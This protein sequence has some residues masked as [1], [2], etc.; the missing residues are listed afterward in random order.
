M[1]IYIYIYG[2]P[3]LMGRLELEPPPRVDKGLNPS[4]T[5]HM[6]SPKSECAHSYMYIYIYIHYIC[7]YIHI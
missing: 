2:W 6:A 1:A 5:I 7:I 3:K 4:L